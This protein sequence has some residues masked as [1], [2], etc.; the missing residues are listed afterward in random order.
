MNNTKEK[1]RMVLKA[2][3]AITPWISIAMILILPFV[4][5]HDLMYG[6]TTSKTLFWGGAVML[7]VFS[8][9]MTNLLK[10]KSIKVD[11]K[12]LDV[13][14]GIYFMYTVIHPYLLD[15]SVDQLYWIEFLSLSAFYLVVRQF[16]KQ[17][18]NLVLVATMLL[19]MIQAIYGNLQLYGIFRSNH[20]LFKL[21]GSFFN[22]GPYAGFL[23]T[24]L[25]I[26]IIYYLSTSKNSK[27][28]R[29]FQTK[30]IN[31]R[32][33]QFVNGLSLITIVS[34]ILVLPATQSRAAW[35]AAICSGIFV[36]MHYRKT[37][38]LNKIQSTPIIKKY[39]SLMINRRFLTILTV[40]VLSI[41]LSG[42]YFFKKNSADGRL[43]IW[44]VSTNM[45]KDKPVL[46][47][48]INKFKAYYMNYQAD[49]FKANPNAPEEMV[50]DNVTYTFNELINVA[51]EKGLLG[52]VL[53]VMILVSIFFRT[54][55]SKRQVFAAKAA[56]M[57]VLIFGLFS[58]P[59][60]IL[61]IKVIVML[62]IAI[63]A[64]YQRTVVCPAIRKYES[65]IAAYI[66]WSMLV[67][68]LAL[69][70]PGS[71]V[72]KQ[73]YYALVTW[74]DATDIYSV[75][76]YA[77]CLDEYEDA[78]EVL[79]NNGVF[80]VAYGKALC[81]AKEYRKAELILTRSRDYLN[82]TILYTALG[83]CFKEQKEFERA[84]D[85]YNKAWHMVPNRFYPLYLLA[86]LYDEIG[87][88]QKAVRTAKLVINKKVKIQSTAV[89]EIRTEMTQIIEKYASW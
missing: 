37:E 31:N 18:L 38:L 82:N 57:G 16:P 69:L 20:G 62:S 23:I 26:A 78:Y 61:P 9:L 58:Y 22:P 29:F 43:F 36:L 30:L 72:L 17:K 70:I 63:I 55:S 21:T 66:N 12:P 34:I 48:G 39:S 2:N 50:A 32:A 1:L 86:K 49:Y 28:S 7:I 84:E 56:L 65:R 71:K 25:P 8:Q 73:Q 24:I 45:V 68:F 85:M 19:G 13:L 64:H 41:F 59:S 14:L 51:V 42:I 33:I 87:D 74:K 46:G 35:L 27:Y 10:K 75:E 47:H 54:T 80:L 89:D 83:D 88:E 67:L 40:V 77:E 79:N 44:K 3:S 76:A 52:A 5:F 60:E 15:Y 53:F 4:Y 6:I 81:M 11:I